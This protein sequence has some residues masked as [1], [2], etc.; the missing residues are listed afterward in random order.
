MIAVVQDFEFDDTLLNY[1]YPGCDWYSYLGN[2][3]CGE[4]KSPDPKNFNRYYFYLPE[5]WDNEHTEGVYALWWS[6]NHPDSGYPGD[7]AKKTYINGLY[8]IDLPKDVE[9]IVWNNAVGEV[10]LDYTFGCS[11]DSFANRNKVFVVDFDK[12]KIENAI[13]KGMNFEE[14]ATTKER[15][16]QMGGHKA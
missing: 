14:G 8:Y 12:S 9:V 2:G 10:S 5:K 3:E 7:K 11:A 16:G 1:D 4:I 6:E 15:N 13:L